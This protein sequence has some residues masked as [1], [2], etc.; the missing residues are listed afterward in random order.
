M[1][2]PPPIRRKTS[3]VRWLVASILFHSLLAVL[4]LQ[5]V[6]APPGRHGGVGSGTDGALQL[7]WIPGDSGTGAGFDTAVPATE[8]DGLDASQSATTS[9]SKTSNDRL[10]A[11]TETDP[12]T[13]FN[14]DGIKSI[15][16]ESTEPAEVESDSQDSNVSQAAIAD[17]VRSPEVA[18][19]SDSGPSGSSR[20][21]AKN[22][23]LSESRPGEHGGGGNGKRAGGPNGNGGVSFFG[24]FARARRIVYAIDASE[25]MRNNRAMEIARNELIASL[26]ALEPS[27]EFQIIFFDV[28]SYSMNRAGE[29][30]TLLKATSTN[31]RLAEKFIKGIQP[32]AGTDR[33]AAVKLAISFKPDV[34]FLLTDADEPEMTTKELF[35]IRRENK[36]GM[37]IHSVEFGVGADLTKDS[38][39]K[40]LAKQNN[41]SHIYRDLVQLSQSR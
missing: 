18:A 15:M 1:S 5:F 27:A 38:F 3:S 8:S 20:D 39:L 37:I 12:Q 34:I 13:I 26:R 32:E 17:A 25:S 4:I 29:K 16:F 11:T 23:D 35:Q 22:H 36:R 10:I 6:N 21:G 24:L 28:K 9:A 7:T 14:N 30:P 2:F 19:D 41:G 33:F 31:L 40:K